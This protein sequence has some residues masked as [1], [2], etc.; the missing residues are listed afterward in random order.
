MY[1]HTATCFLFSLF[2]SFHVTLLPSDLKYVLGFLE[3]RLSHCLQI[4]K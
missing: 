4:E 2:L 1:V 3:S